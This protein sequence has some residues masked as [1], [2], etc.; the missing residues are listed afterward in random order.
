MK[1]KTKLLTGTGILICTIIAILF[2]LHFLSYSVV[3]DPVG[4]RL[5]A[6]TVGEQY[7]VVSGF[8]YGGMYNYRSYTTQYS[9]GVLCIK[10]SGGFDMPW[11]EGRNSPDFCPVLNNYEGVSQI[12]LSSAWEDKRRLIWSE[13]KGAVT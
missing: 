10:Y 5:E 1:T 4:L 12:Y 13:D 7:I 11:L 8:N 9:D 3:A 6:V 2:T